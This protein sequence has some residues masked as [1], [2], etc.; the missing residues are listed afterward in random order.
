MK[1]FLKNSAILAVA[2]LLVAG[3]DKDTEDC[4]T[5]ST[6]PELTVLGDPI[7]SLRL[8]GSYTDQ[9]CKAECDG[10]DISNTITMRSTIN[11]I[12]PGFYKV[13]YTARNADGAA[14]TATR[15]V[16]VCD[17]NNFASPY[18]GESKFGSRNYKNAPITITDLGD[19]LFEID[20]LAGGFYF[21]GR[22]PGYE[23]TYD[24]HLEATLKLNSDNTIELAEC[25]GDNWYW[26]EGMTLTE[27]KYDPATGTVTLVLNFSG[28]PLYVT[29]TK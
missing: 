22:Y 10:Q 21:N 13:I 24:F 9:G 2:M 11:P 4:S 23:P 5:I 17:P 20:D 25:N 26:G 27:G 14:G 19:N 12:V 29:L 15:T 28:S 1:K 7:V 18:F 16:M 6:I 8:G 3:C